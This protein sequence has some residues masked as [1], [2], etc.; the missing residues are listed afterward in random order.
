M[1]RTRLVSALAMAALAAIL[2]PSFLH[3]QVTFQ[4][5]YGGPEYDAGSE[6]RQT[7]DGGYIVAGTTSS[8]GAGSYDVYLIKTD[9]SG[10]TVWTRTFGGEWIDVGQAVQQTADGGYIIA[11]T[12]SSNGAGGLDFYLLK[13]DADG[14]R[15]WSR[16]FGGTADDSGCSVQQTADSGYVIAGYTESFGAGQ[17]DVYLIKTD[18]IGDTL[19]TRTFGGSGRDYGL[20]VGQTSDDGYI[21]AGYT[22]SFGAGDC[23]VYLVKT[24]AQGDAQW[25]RAFGGVSEEFGYSVQQTTDSGYIIAGSTASFGAGGYD[26][27]LVRT[28]RDGDTLWTRTYGGASYD[29]GYYVRQTADS[30]FVVGGSSGS[31]GAGNADSYIVRTNADGDTLWT[32]TFGGTYTDHGSSAQQTIDGG[33]VITGYT[34]S[35]GAGAADVYLVKTDSLGNVAVAEPKASPSR[36][37]ALSLT[38][39]PNPASGSVTI[40][41]S[42]SI[43]LSPSPILRVYDSQGR[44]VLSREVSTSPFP[45][46]ASDLPSG[47][48]FV[49]LDAGSEHATTRIVLQR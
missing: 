47:A 24:D 11:G 1:N 12:T 36:A 40:S 6:V 33:Y 41:L 35:F 38:C 32:R 13:T 21:I 14:D 34:W 25:T 26:A 48:Y 31:F 3:A 10:D 17:W 22:T 8:F 20:S 23:D 44:M 30:G 18:S 2:L 4:R 29:N 9:A 15:L 45:L 49:R 43:P 28:D 27:Y 39:T 16:T 37:P 7:T 5:T 46:S 19:W 42:P